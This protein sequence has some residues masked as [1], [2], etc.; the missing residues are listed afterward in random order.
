MKSIASLLLAGAVLVIMTLTI[1]L[2]ASAQSSPSG[3]FRVAEAGSCKGWLATCNSRC[4]HTV[5]CSPGFCAAK[6][7][8][9]RQTGCFVE[10][11]TYGNVSHC[12]L[13]K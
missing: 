8:T 12:G 13:A 11:P 5:Q 3:S 7:E 4:G 6:Y 1:S 10:G 9:C 2:A